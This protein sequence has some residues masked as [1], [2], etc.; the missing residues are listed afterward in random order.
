MYLCIHEDYNENRFVNQQQKE[1]KTSGGK[2]FMPEM[3]L[4]TQ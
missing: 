1:N 3:S 4:H 2:N